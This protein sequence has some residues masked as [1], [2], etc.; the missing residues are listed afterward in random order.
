MFGTAA[1]KKLYSWWNILDT[2]LEQMNER[3]SFSVPHELW[4]TAGKVRVGDSV[5]GRRVLS[6]K[7]PH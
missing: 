1:S 3:N 4:R 7:L 2:D 6:G 5:G